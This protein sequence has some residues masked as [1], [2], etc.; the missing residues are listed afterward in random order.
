MQIA[1]ESG[2]HAP[3]QGLVVQRLAQETNRSGFKQSRPNSVIR[4]GRDSGRFAMK[5][6]AEAAKW[7]IVFRLLGPGLVTGGSTCARVS[8]DHLVGAGEKRGRYFETE[9]ASGL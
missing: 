5:R 1:P 6:I 9:G 7:N 4:E 3:D 8:F 2:I